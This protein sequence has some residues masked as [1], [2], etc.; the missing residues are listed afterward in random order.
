MESFEDRVAVCAVGVGGSS[1]GVRVFS[2]FPR[3]KLTL[4][5]SYELV[6]LVE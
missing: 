6:I 4:S 1:F 2:P 3:G 5:S